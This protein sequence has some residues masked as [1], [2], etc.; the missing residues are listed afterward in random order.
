MK[1]LKKHIPIALL[2]TSLGFGFNINCMQKQEFLKGSSIEQTI[3][4]SNT[5]RQVIDGKKYL[6][7][8]VK[9]KKYDN[10]SFYTDSMVKVLDNAKLK[11]FYAQYYCCTDVEGNF[12]QD[13]L[14]LQGYPGLPNRVT[15]YGKR[16]SSSK[17]VI[18]K[19]ILD[20]FVFYDFNKDCSIVSEE[21]KREEV[22]DLGLRKLQLFN[23]LFNIEEKK[24]QSKGENLYPLLDEFNIDGLTV[25]DFKTYDEFEEGV[26]AEFTKGE[27]PFI[28]V[29]YSKALD[30]NS[31]GITISLLNPVGQMTIEDREYDGRI[32]TVLLEKGGMPSFGTTVF[33]AEGD[34]YKYIKDIYT[35][36]QVKEI[37]VDAEQKLNLINKIVGE[38][39]ER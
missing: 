12:D 22:F 34:T 24:K 3:K 32:D 38:K 33:V 8:N 35:E 30:L 5:E 19:V 13:I 1:G 10:K 6:L 37:F 27:K 16:G 17:T 31:P 4:E 18:E 28:L 11:E 2:V 29:T 39:N 23:K 7:T 9:Y 21:G 14:D 25:K 36:E 15:I 26:F 20:D